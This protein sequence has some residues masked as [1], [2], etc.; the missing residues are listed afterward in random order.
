[1]RS[2]YDQFGPELDL[3]GDSKKAMRMNTHAREIL[4]WYS[5]DNPGT[6]TNLTRLLRHGYLGGTG[7]LQ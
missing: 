1:M 2:P 7:R 4:G 6:L 3:R 5:G